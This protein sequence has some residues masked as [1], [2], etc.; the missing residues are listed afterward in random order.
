QDPNKDISRIE[1]LIN[2]ESVKSVSDL[3]TEKIS[4]E[5]PPD[6]IKIGEN[7][8]LFR[9]YCKGDDL[10]ASLFIFKEST[11]NS[12]IKDSYVMIGNRMYKVV[13]TTSNE[14][15]ITITLDRGLEEDLNLGDPIY[16]LINKTKVQVKINK[17][18]LFKDMKL[19]E[20]KKSDSSYQ[21]IYE[22]EEAN[23]K[24]AQP[25]IIVEK[26]DKWTAIK[27]P[28]MIF[29]YDAENNEPQA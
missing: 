21:E 16:Q 1:M 5:V 22:L 9:A 3:T 17:S 14:Q 29:R 13:N 23:I 26:G 18:D 19:V 24:S 11:G 6:K 10:Y 15:D 7:K 28:S 2:G 8:I 25:K 12:I 27:R 20:I 4:F